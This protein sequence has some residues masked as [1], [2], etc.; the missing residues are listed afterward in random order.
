[1]LDITQK[2]KHGLN[3]L[4]IRKN[5]HE[6]QRKSTRIGKLPELH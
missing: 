1:M 4:N 6:K 3:Y 5:N 2:L